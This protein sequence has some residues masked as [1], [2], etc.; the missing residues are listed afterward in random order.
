VILDGH[1]RIFLD[2]VSHL[3]PMLYRFAKIGC[4][5]IS[6]YKVGHVGR[7]GCPGRLT[8]LYGLQGA[9]NLKGGFSAIDDIA[10][11]TKN[12]ALAN[13]LPRP[14]NDTEGTKIIAMFEMLCADSPLLYNPLHA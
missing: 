3:K 2:F 6:P 11:K 4:G 1:V 5:S 7:A 12:M 10:L 14:L 9:C 8:E 13:P